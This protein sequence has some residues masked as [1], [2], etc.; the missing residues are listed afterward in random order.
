MARCPNCKTEVANP[1]KEWKYGVFKV[2]MYKCLCG[3]QFR[4]YFKGDRL[5]FILSGHDG[6]LGPKIK[7]KT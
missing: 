4:E 3:N 5:S 6:G 1:T 7:P 2:R